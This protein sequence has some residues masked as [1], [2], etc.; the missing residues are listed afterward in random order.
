MK[1]WQYVVGFVFTPDYSK[2][3][4]MK[5][6]KPEWQKGKLNG[7]GGK[8][9]KNET[10]LA[11]MIREA[12]EETGLETPQWKE[13]AVLQGENND[14]AGFNLNCFFTTTDQTLL[15][16]EDQ[17]EEV[18]LYDVDEVKSHPCIGNVP[19]LIEA[20]IYKAKQSSNFKKMVMQY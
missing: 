14:G 4:L 16:L 19:T 18:G 2:V 9:E 7:I 1:I 6:Q 17:G 5:K 11:A 8:I 15:T 20:C 12:K 10:P 13:F 3:W